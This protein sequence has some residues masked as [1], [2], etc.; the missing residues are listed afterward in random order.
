[1]NKS[2][3]TYWDIFKKDICANKIIF[4]SSLITAIACFGFTITSFSIGVD[5]PMREYYLYSNGW[6]SMIQQG[7]LLHV[8]F[9]AL[10]GLVDFIPFLNDFIAVCLFLL[11]AL[12]LAA[13]F[14]HIA[15]SKFSTFSVAAFCCIYISYSIITEKFIYNLDVIVTMISYCCCVLSLMYAYRFVEE[16]SK[17]CFLKSIITLIVALGSY[18]SF[19]FLYFCGVFGLFIVQMCINNEKIRFKEFIQKGLQYALILII[20]IVIYYSTVALVQ[21]ATN[22]YGVFARNNA[23]KNV[24]GIFQ[25]F[26]IITKAL[27]KDFL[28][29]DYFPLL[30]FFIASVLGAVFFIVYSIKKRNLILFIS[31]CGLFAGNLFIHYSCGYVMYRAAQTFCLFIALIALI[32][33]QKAQKVNMLKKPLILFVALIV[34][35]QTADMNKWFYN[36]YNRYQKDSFVINTIATR[37]ASEFDV[38]KPVVFVNAPQNGYLSNTNRTNQVNGVSMVYWGID[39]FSKQAI[40]YVFDAYGYDFIKEPTAEQIQQAQKLSENMDCWP[41]KNCIIETESFIV[42]N[43]NDITQ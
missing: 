41:S 27:I 17:I 19:I 36:D 3:N 6:G 9:N 14:Q 34:T 20:S 18:E 39:G 26:L 40:Y 43:F 29:L 37:L 23:W 16:K 35:L 8:V 10:T 28:V 13:L 25:N 1:M 22:Q 2:K 31:F 21:I 42:V 4:F 11:S 38:S 12:L 7:R 15:N 5:D 32:F 24:S 30:E 33:L